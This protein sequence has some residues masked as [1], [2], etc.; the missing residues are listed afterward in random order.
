VLEN[1]GD[2]QLPGCPLF[3]G[4]SNVDKCRF[5]KTIRQIKLGD[6]KLDFLGKNTHCT[7]V[8]YDEAY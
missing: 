5:L 7:R 4:L 6:K 3:V 8:N 2:G 1:F